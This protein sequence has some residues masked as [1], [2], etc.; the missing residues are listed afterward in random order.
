M[1]SKPLPWPC[2]T[3]VSLDLIAL[4]DVQYN[5]MPVKTKNHQSKKYPQHFSKVYWPYLPLIILV[6]TGL[7]LGHPN[8]EKSQRGVLAYATDVNSSALLAETNHARQG[9]HKPNLTQNSLLDKAATAKAQDMVARNYWSHLTP[10][11]KTPWSFID[12]YGYKYQKAGENLAYGFAGSDEVVKGWLNSPAHKANLLDG[13]YRDVGFGIVNSPDFQGNGPETI[14]VALYAKAGTIPVSGDTSTRLSNLSAFSTENPLAR[15]TSQTI[16]KAQALT[17]GK[18]PWIS[19]VLGLAG[20][21]ALAFV[22]IKHSVLIHRRIRKGEKYVL[23]HPVID[24]TIIVFVA[25]CA[26][27]SQSIGLIK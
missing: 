3:V 19:F 25:V 15:E 10:D 4:S 26:I 24:A 17:G 13:D 8:V 1:L 27:L 14:V 11:G 6:I 23:K 2:I 18:M 12:I 9:Q 21:F 22:L 5:L 16:S 7:W 20:G